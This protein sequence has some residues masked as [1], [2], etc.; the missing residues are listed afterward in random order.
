MRLSTDA[1]RDEARALATIA[2]ALDAGASWLDT[3]RSYARDAGELGHNERLVARALGSRGGVRV[4][5]KC[6]MRRPG[7]RWEP[8][9]RVRAVLE[10]ARGSL[11]DLGRAPDVLLLHA[12]DP[13]VPLTTS[14]RGLVRA[15]EEGLARAIGLSNV[16]RK[17]LES[18]PADVDL[19]AV[20]VALGAHD[21]AAA[22]GGVLAWCKDRGITVLAHA[23]LGGPS[24]AGKLERDPVLRA[25]AARHEQTTPAMILLAYLLAVSDVVVPVV[26]ARRPETARAALAAERIVLDEASLAEL[27]ARF[28]GLAMTRRPARAPS[29][30]KATAEVVVVMGVVGSGK[31]RL[32]ESFVAR[33]YERLNRDS[34][35]GTLAGIAKR[36]GERLAA[37]ST[38]IVLDNTYVTRASRSEVLRVAH[39]AGAMV[40]C[41]H[42]ET[43]S[44]EAQ[45]N[46]AW[47]MLERHGE[48]LGGAE[49][50]RRAK[51]DAG[52][53]AP[54]T[55]SRME[56]QLE[57]PA[58]DEGF[59]SIEQVPFSRAHAAAPGA[60]GVAIPIELVVEDRAGDLVR[61]G[62]AEAALGRVPP[63]APVL[64][65]G[66]RHGA[67]DV[68]RAKAAALAS[69]I[70][71]GRL[72]EIG[73]CAHAPG[74]PVC[75]CRPPLPGLW[76]EF[77]RRHGIDPRVSLF[78]TTTPAQRAMAR[79]L[80]IQV[81]EGP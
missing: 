52:L 65:Y 44:H 41:I 69:A 66:W 19:A 51:K 55:L 40:R 48:L 54:A 31:T 15:R 21:D 26:G 6:G 70:A 10:D 59:S 32:A 12:P 8:D 7:G 16:T 42:L 80:G 3:A 62:G 29:P 58:H 49:L 39:A 77:A 68:W 23:P 22:R 67:D 61:R 43:P 24:R 14:V 1:E 75:W 20:E 4:V 18:L 9:G 53:F 81:F 33:G 5:T 38:R 76:L 45:V 60:S 63:S 50:A 47:R 71:G 64:L 27:D 56:R 36:L 57:R 73:I 37:G 35:G 78:V 28:P 30:E 17:Q 25:I 79:T 46:V 74:P 11:R 13:R 72:V 2:A 34:L